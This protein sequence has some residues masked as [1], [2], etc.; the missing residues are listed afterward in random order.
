MKCM[1]VII[2]HF[3]WLVIATW[4]F[5]DQVPMRGKKTGWTT[6]FHRQNT[7]SD[8]HVSWEPQPATWSP[9]WSKCSWEQVRK[10]V[11]V[12]LYVNMNIG[13]SVGQFVS[14]LVYH[15]FSRR[16]VGRFQWVGPSVSVDRSSVGQS[17]VGQSMC[18]SV[19]QSLVGPCVGQY[20]LVDVLVGVS[21]GML[22]CVDVS[23]GVSVGM[24][25]GLLFVSCLVCRSVGLSVC[26]S[27][28]SWSSF[29][30]SVSWCW[31][32][33]V[34]VGVSFDV[35]VYWS[36]VV[37]SLSICQSFIWSFIYSVGRCVGRCVGHRSFGVCQWM[38]VSWCVLVI[39]S[40][41]V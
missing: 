31:S 8:F 7:T 12:Y 6:C 16:S 26:W 11:C 18:G 32:V 14:P 19:C 29:G 5:Q 34:S 13:M 4:F 38:L 25:V 3:M 39:V 2:L 1:H 10:Y 9:R 40:V 20:L 30:W 36:L 24:S 27:S 33:G 41:G 35:L 23:V 28:I 21:V 17:S 22:V 37:H 15:S